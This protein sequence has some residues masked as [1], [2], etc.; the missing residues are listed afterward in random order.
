MRAGRRS[1]LRSSELLRGPTVLGRTNP[2][3]GTGHRVS[4]D[5]VEPGIEIVRPKSIQK[6]ESRTGAVRISVKEHLRREGV[7]DIAIPDAWGM[8]RWD[9]RWE[10]WVRFEKNQSHAIRASDEVPPSLDEAIRKV[11]QIIPSFRLR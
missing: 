4:S 7:G 1:G 5:S 10:D 6:R 2:E 11:I 9:S 3:G 8:S